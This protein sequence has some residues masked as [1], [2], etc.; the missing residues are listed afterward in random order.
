M[1]QRLFLVSA[2]VLL[3]QC[4]LAQAT[5][6]FAKK[7]DP[8]VQEIPFGLFDNPTRDQ[9]KSITDQT[10]FCARGPAESF[11]CKSDHYH[12]FLDHPDRAVTAWRRMG[13][14]CVSIQPL[15]NDHFSWS[16]DN[17]GKVTW[18]TVHRGQG[19]RVWVAEGK[20]RPLA[21]MRLVPVKVVVILRYTENK[22]AE[23][24]A[25]ITHQTDL[26]VHT[27]SD[28]LSLAAKVLGGSVKGKAEEGLG[29]FQMFF[30]Y[31]SWRLHR[32]P[33][34]VAALLKGN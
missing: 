26:F 18:E 6:L 33:E 5:N 19:V 1:I 7:V 28:V 12:Y 14:K 25:T 27:E 24:V 11:T 9:V 2:T 34:Q 3:A 13:A 17:G 31:L 21:V 20:V 15:A 32:H 23:G 8:L 10:T 4:Q 22:N 16:D 30:S 29:Q